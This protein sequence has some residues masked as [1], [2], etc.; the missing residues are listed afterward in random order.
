MVVDVGDPK[1]TADGRVAE[2]NA[3]VP[4][5]QS[6]RPCARNSVPIKYNNYCTLVKTR[7]FTRSRSSNPCS[8][9][10]AYR[11]HAQTTSEDA[12]RYTI[13]LMYYT[14]NPTT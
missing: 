12:D 10:R 7:R 13:T 4:S 9:S 2:A 3:R 5:Q 11:D 6:F 1:K 14:R 8:S